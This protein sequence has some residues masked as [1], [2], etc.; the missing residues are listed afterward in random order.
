MDFKDKWMNE[1][2]YVIVIDIGTTKSDIY[3]ELLV[4][5]KHSSP[6]CSSNIIYTPPP[7]GYALNMSTWVYQ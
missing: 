1:E 2:K 3:L 5:C 6:F 7:G 4:N